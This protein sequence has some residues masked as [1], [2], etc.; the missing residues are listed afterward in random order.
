MIN[1]SN[2]IPAKKNGVLV[3]IGDTEFFNKQIS[4]SL[5]IADDVITRAI[6][7]AT[8]GVIIAKGSE[9]FKENFDLELNISDKISFK[10]YF[11]QTYSRKKGF[12]K[13]L[14]K[15]NKNIGYYRILKDTDIEAK[16]TNQL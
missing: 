7:S 14:G 13:I 11:G 10:G 8:E 12:Y 16:C 15:E 1:D 5:F 9:A 2:L 4:A 3:Y 6:S